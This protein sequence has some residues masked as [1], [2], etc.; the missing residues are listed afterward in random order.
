MTSTSAIRVGRIRTLLFASTLAIATTQPWS[1]SVN[2]F[3]PADD[4]ASPYYLGQ[5]APPAWQGRP[6]AIPELGGFG[7]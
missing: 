2:G 4:P 3:S 1:A 7:E 6:L 5:I